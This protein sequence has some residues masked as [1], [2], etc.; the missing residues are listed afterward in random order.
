MRLPFAILLI[1]FIGG[2]TVL[3][4]AEVHSLIFWNNVPFA[5]RL[6][7]LKSVTDTDNITVLKVVNITWDGH[8]PVERCYMQFYGTTYYKMLW[9]VGGKW[10]TED[11]SQHK[12]TGSFT[13]AVVRDERPL[14]AEFADKGLVNANMYNLKKRLRQQFPGF[15]YLVHASETSAEAAS[16]LWYLFRSDSAREY[17]QTQQVWDMVSVESVVHPCVR[18]WIAIV[19]A[20]SAPLRPISAHEA[21]PPPS[22]F[23]VTGGLLTELFA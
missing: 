12:G 23:C 13:A 22:L 15:S 6:S 11:M 16:D 9:N 7:M 10:V 3:C 21:C 4:E 5:Q 17:L 18:P 14:Y 2:T 1:V 8:L 20:T 19:N